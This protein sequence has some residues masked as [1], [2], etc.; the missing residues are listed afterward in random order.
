MSRLDSPAAH[1]AA[2]APRWPAAALLLAAALAAPAHAQL[3]AD[4][5]A[6]KA[7]IDLRTRVTQADERSRAQTEQLQT[8][9]RSLLDLNRQIELLRGEIAQLRGSNELLQRDLAELQKRQRDQAQAFDERLRRFEP[10]KVML[11]GQEFEAGA[12]EKRQFEEALAL[13]RAGEFDRAAQ[14]FGAF[15]SRWPNSGY[16][17]PARFWQGNALYGKRDYAQAIAAFRAYL[18]AAPDGPRAPEA[19]L[20][21]ANSQLESKDP[22]AARKTLGELIKAYPKSEAAVAARERLGNLK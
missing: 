21:I 3:F 12:D 15:P 7:I 8:L 6:R 18:A 17:A 2:R 13:L 22:K 5:E 14:A 16:A 9:Q 20:A 11:D 19:A 4:D 1:G 10:Q